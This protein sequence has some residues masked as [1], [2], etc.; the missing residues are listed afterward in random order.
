M[1][2]VLEATFTETE[3]ASRKLAEKRLV[4]KRESERAREEREMKGVVEK[5]LESIKR[6]ASLR[7]GQKV[8]TT[9][10]TEVVGAKRKSSVK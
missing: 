5:R 2:E 1:K 4:E 7:V 6:K 9:K 10:T 8:K 3:K